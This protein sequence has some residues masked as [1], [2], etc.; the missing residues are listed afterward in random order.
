MYYSYTSIY[1][2]KKIWSF[3]WGAS[4][5]I[6]TEFD[7]PQTFNSQTIISVGSHKALAIH[8]A[9]AKQATEKLSQNWSMLVIGD[10][11]KSF[12]LDIKKSH[13]NWQCILQIV[14]GF[15]EFTML[16]CSNI[17][18]CKLKSVTIYNLMQCA[19]SCGTFTVRL[20]TLARVMKME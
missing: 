3:V 19:S 16:I 8:P 6:D 10:S 7:K 9:V 14:N 12:I 13:P 17:Q 11:I 1:T 18:L 20:T 5:L 15:I 4:N 2:E